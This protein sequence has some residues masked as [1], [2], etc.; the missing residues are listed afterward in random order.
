MPVQ[1]A[2]VARD[3]APAARSILAGEPTR[4]SPRP[5]RSRTRRRHFWGESRCATAVTQ[6]GV[7]VSV[8]ESVWLAVL[9][10]PMPARERMRADHWV[11]ECYAL[12]TWHLHFRAVHVSSLGPGGNCER[13]V[14]TDAGLDTIN[15]KPHHL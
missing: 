15:E 1:V 7:T 5:F 3:D 6:D 13:G 10:L 11:G 8:L 4:C 9:Q 14:N 12:E 2:V